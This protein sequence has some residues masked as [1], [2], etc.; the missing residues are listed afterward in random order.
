MFAIKEGM[1]RKRL[2]MIIYMKMKGRSESLNKGLDFDELR[3]V[4]PHWDRRG[5][6]MEE[7]Q[8]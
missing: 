6:E 5:Y 1:R 3:L 2:N 8:N 7:Y 4:F